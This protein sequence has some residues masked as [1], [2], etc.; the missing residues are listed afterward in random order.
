MDETSEP[1][2][3][4]MGW[5]YAK[6]IIVNKCR[7]LK[8]EKLHYFLALGNVSVASYDIRLP[9]R[10]LGISS[11]VHYAELNQSLCSV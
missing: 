11:L 10:S 2:L 8:E 4:R 5:V 3:N 6:A 1:S 7:S 9:K